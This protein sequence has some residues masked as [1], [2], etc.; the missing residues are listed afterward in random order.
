M[1]HVAL[2]TSPHSLAHAAAPDEL[3]FLPYY[4]LF[5]HGA[6]SSVPPFDNIAQV[7][8][9]LNRT[10]DFV[11]PWRSDLWNAIT[12]AVTGANPAGWRRHAQHHTRVV[13]LR[14]AL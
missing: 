14:A 13:H 5:K 3:T 4:T 11:Q 8:A 1:P 12:M 6:L 2:G 7:Y 9:S 10:F